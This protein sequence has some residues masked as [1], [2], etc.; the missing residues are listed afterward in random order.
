[1]IFR[2]GTAPASRIAEEV[3]RTEVS[4]SIGVSVGFGVLV[5]A[6]ASVGTD[7]LVAVEV[8]V[9]VEGEGAFDAVEPRAALHSVK[10]ATT[11]PRTQYGRM[12]SRF[13]ANPFPQGP[14]KRFNVPDP[15]QVQSIIIIWETGWKFVRES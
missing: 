10:A 15:E 13:I 14:V 3:E 1:M 9:P 7:V 11:S 4:I 2:K 8:R 5:G 12:N 6:G